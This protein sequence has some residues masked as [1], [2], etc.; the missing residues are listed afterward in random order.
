MNELKYLYYWNKKKAWKNE[1]STT[2]DVT[3]QTKLIHLKSLF[4]A[5]DLKPC[6]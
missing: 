4:L 3:V 2:T 6:R 5:G 1:S